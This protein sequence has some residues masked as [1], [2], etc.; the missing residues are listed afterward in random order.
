MYQ[1]LVALVELGVVDIEKSLAL[2]KDSDIEGDA[3]LA[4]ALDIIKAL[5]GGKRQTCRTV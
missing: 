3:I 2:E 4:K 5:Q 1:L